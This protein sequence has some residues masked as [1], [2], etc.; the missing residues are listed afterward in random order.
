MFGLCSDDDDVYA[1]DEDGDFGDQSGDGDDGGSGYDVAPPPQ[2][3]HRVNT[4]FTHRSRYPHQLPRVP[5]DP[6]HYVDPSLRQPT[7]T[8][9]R[10]VMYTAAAAA[11]PVIYTTP[12]DVFLT[13]RWTRVSN[14]ASSRHSRLVLTMLLPAVVTV[15]R[16]VVVCDT[17]SAVS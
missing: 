7:S 8:H 3:R 15:S 12:G 16:L 11:G 10:P 13:P 1:D 5:V 9:R 6:R 17:F 2:P 14:K 4:Q